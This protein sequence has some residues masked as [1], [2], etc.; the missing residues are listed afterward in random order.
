MAAYRISARNRSGRRLTPPQLQQ[1]PER[2][3]FYEYVQSLTVILKLANLRQGRRV[4]EGEHSA[5]WNQQPRQ[6][7]KEEN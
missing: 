2:R 3:F 5:L 4:P 1:F 7:E 6:N